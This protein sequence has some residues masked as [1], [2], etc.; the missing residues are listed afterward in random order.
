MKKPWV[1]SI[2]ASIP[3]AILVIPLNI[4]LHGREEKFSY[5]IL[6]DLFFFFYIIYFYPSEG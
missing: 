5:S 6:K 4:C 2:Q 3:I 1:L